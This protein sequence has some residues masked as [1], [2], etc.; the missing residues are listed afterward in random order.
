MSEQI[1]VLMI[2]SE[3]PSLDHP[4]AVPFLVQQVEFLRSAGVLVEV[5]PFR[6]AKRPF[7]YFMAWM[8]LRQK[9]SQRNYD[10]IHAQFGQ[11]AL[12]AWPQRLPLVITFR[13]CDIQGVRRANGRITLSGKILQ[14]LCRIMALRAQAVILVSNR[15]RRLIPVS[16]PAVVIPTGLDLEQIP[17]VSRTEARRRLR[18]PNSDQLVLFVGNPADTVKRYK[19]AESA[20][21]VLNRVHP[22]KLIVG[23]GLPRREIL[24]LMNACD[25]LVLTS[26]QEGSPNVIKEALACDL[27]V[28]SLDVGDVAEHVQSLSGCEICPD[29]QPETIAACLERVLRRGQRINGRERVQDL[30][31]KILTQRI[32]GIYSSVL[33]NRPHQQ[34]SGRVIS[35]WRSLLHLREAEPRKGT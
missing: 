25:A 21:E 23:W 20:V 17:R 15:M 9:L 16:V 14:H 28:V 18:L 8:N 6:G 32:I 3:W 4:H 13:G 33:A 5:F 12:L 30:D 26:I 24:L 11:S 19:L 29:S 35:W 10:L 31:E 2:T 27:P 7:N 22:A 34:T 1:R